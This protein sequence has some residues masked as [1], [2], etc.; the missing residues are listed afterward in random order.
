MAMTSAMRALI[1]APILK[2]TFLASL[3][4]VATSQPKFEDYPVKEIFRGTPASPVLSTPETRRFRTELRRQ[5]AT[6]ANFAGHFMLARWGCGAGCVSV[7][8]IDS[9]SGAVYF[10]PFSFQDTIV[11]IDGKPNSACNHASDFQ[12]DSE[13]FIAQ[14]EI[15]EKT[16]RHY[17]RWHD[18]RFTL[19]HFEPRCEF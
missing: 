4:G 13:L 15:K 14:G 11:L 16:G 1:L 7:A 17:Y 19:V 3:G 12:I 2:A 8:V 10:A 18:R 9:I 6:G 5:A